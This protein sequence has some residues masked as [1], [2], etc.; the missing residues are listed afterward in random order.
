MTRCGSSRPRSLRGWRMSASASPSITSRMAAASPTSPP[1]GRIARPHGRN[2]MW[3]RE[4]EVVARQLPAPLSVVVAGYHSDE[5]KQP[6]VFF[7]RRQESGP[8]LTQGPLPFLS[9]FIA[10]LTLVTRLGECIMQFPQLGQCFAA[11]KAIAMFAHGVARLPLHI[12]SEGC[13]LN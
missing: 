10:E 11:V 2:C 8:C 4:T 6:L 9:S 7:G 12:V 5:R 1:W 3:V 13:H